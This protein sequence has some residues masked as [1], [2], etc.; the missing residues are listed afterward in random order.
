MKV[1]ETK[2]SLAKILQPFRHTTIG[3]VP[4]MGA[5]HEGHIS[6][7]KRCKENKIRVASIFVNPTQ[8]ND[9]SD[10]V[11][12]PRRLDKDLKMLSSAGCDFVFAPTE[13]EMY[14]EEDTRE[15]D[16]GMLEKVMEGAHRPGHFNGVAQIVSK[17]FDIVQPNKAYF[18]EKDF[19]QLAIIRQLVEIMN[20][21]VQIVSCPTIRESNG[22]A[23]SSRNLLLTPN[24]RKNASIIPRTLFACKEKIRSTSLYDLKKWAIEKIDS[25]PEFQTEYFDIVDRYTLQT[26]A[27]YEFDALQACVAVR[28]GNIRLIDNVGI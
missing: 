22:L 13:A 16:F 21:N 24:Q 23:M 26:A 1:L 20:Y 28:V 9:R 5:L 6:L 4:T 17:L 18:G 12:Y 14:P 7:M 25:V 2:E 3:F 19:Q 8:F 10:L 27:E 11:N 15:F